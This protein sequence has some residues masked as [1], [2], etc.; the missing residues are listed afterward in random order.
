[1]LNAPMHEARLYSP[2]ADGSLEC[3][4]CERRCRL[5]T[6]VRGLCRNYMNIG[7]RLYSLGYGRLSAVESRPIEVKPLYHYWPN[8]TALTFSTFGCNFYCPWCQNHFLSFRDPGSDV[9]LMD[10]AHLVKL[11]RISGD[12]GL[13]ASFNEPTVNYEYLIDV[14]D[15]ARSE[16]L[17]LSI[18]TNGYQTPEALDE[19]VEVGFDGWSVDIKGC[20]GM[21]RALPGIDH[22]KVFRNARRVLD[23]GGHVEMVYLVVTRTNDYDECSEWIIDNHLS[24][25][26]PEVPLHINRYY[27]AHKWREE[28][29]QLRKLLDIYARARKGGIEYVYVG[30]VGI[31]ELETTKCPK[32]GKILVERYNYSVTGFSLVR[33]GGTYRCPRCGYKI[34]LRG[35]YSNSNS[36]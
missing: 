7:G 14:A 3:L 36:R 33:E 34:P 6:G 1:M 16:E 5:R 24:K 19:L 25:L 32:C 11:A 26:G 30:N 27:P 28:A 15:I 4:V 29:T 21:R 10:P 23:L 31:P 18:V 8:S 13:S 17:Y 2:R 9:P 35:M 12:K 22:S 20:P